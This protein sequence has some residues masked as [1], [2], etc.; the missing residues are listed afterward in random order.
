M[1]VPEGA[2]TIGSKLYLF[3]SA[4]KTNQCLI[5]AHGGYHRDNRAFT[6]PKDVTVNF[7]VPHGYKM[8]DPG[9]EHMNLNLQGNE[10]QQYTEGTECVDYCLDKYQGSHNVVGETYESIG[11]FISK[12]N[13]RVAE[14]ASKKEAT[15]SNAARDFYQKAADML[16][17]VSVVTIRNRSFSAEVTLSYVVARVRDVR[18]DIDT[19]H[20]SF[21]RSEAPGLFFAKDSPGAALGEFKM[22]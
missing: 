20:C 8:L 16:Q 22:G 19:F 7:Y 2:I 4:T 11:S 1:S 13:I 17:T 3:P 9:L 6:I 14:L 15:T 18:P 5:S 12:A 10:S 21:C